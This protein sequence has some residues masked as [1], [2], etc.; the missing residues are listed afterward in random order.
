MVEYS[1]ACP[2]DQRP[3][4]RLRMAP[5]TTSTPPTALAA[6]PWRIALVITELEPGGAE[7]C[8]VNLATRLDPARFQVAVYALA[9]RPSTPRHRLVERLEASG[10]PVQFLGCDRWWQVFPALRSL[11]QLLAQQRPQIV[12]TFLFHANIVGLWAARRA[13]VPHVVTSV[14][15]ADP[16]P[17]RMW[18][19]RWGTARADRIVCV[20]Q[21]VAEHC[22]RY[23]F[24]NEKLTVIPNGVDLTRLSCIQPADLQTLGVAPGHK[25]LIFAGRLDRQKGIDAF[26]PYVA[27]ILVDDPD[28]E[29]LI[30]GDGPL[31][32]RLEQQASA[33]PAA[34]RIHFLG[35]QPDIAPLVAA[36]EVL[37]LP[38]RWEGMPNVVLEAMACGKPVLATRTEGVSELLGDNAGEQTLSVEDW[39][40]LAG[41][42]REWLADPACRQ[43]LGRANLSRAKQFAIEKMVDQYAEMYERILATRGQRDR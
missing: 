29:W 31:R 16:R 23:G 32:R 25:V 1:A 20:S 13:G 41:R 30:V 26:F 12:Q 43:R 33:S 38:S 17:W 6:P 37:L 11:S 14:R 15:V 40:G 10:L 27:Q 5:A 36:S 34:R 24:P 4:D 39:E 35:W 8:L 2:L 3:W 22:L 9:S 7:G 18:L 28:W 42:L 21:N 19:E